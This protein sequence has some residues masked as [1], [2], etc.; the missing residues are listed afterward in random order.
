MPPLGSCEKR[1]APSFLFLF[2]FA[3]FFKSLFSFYNFKSYFDTH[4]VI[5]ILIKYIRLIFS[6]SLFFPI[7]KYMLLQKICKIFMRWTDA[8]LVHIILFTFC[9]I[10]V[11]VKHN[12]L[13]KVYTI[14]ALILFCLSI[15][16]PI[17]LYFNIYAWPWSWYPYVSYLYLKESVL[18]M[19]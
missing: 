18:P 13:W 4:C 11:I 17:I 16:I 10:N 15:F 12:S 6:F 5:F 3:L 7:L 19:E 14:L 9:N 2:Y 8:K 1:S